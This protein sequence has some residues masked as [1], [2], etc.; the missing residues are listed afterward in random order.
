MQS[1]AENDDSAGCQPAHVLL[2]ALAEFAAGA[3]HEINNPLA[4]INGRAKILLEEIT[5][6]EH[7]K[8]L[9]V[10]IAQVKRAYEMIAD[11]R[12]FARPP[13]PEKTT[14]DVVAELELIAEEQRS[15]IQEDRVTVA[16]ET[17]VDSFFVSMDRTLF[18]T[19]VLFLCN[20]ARDSLHLTG[21]KIIIRLT[22]PDED[23]IEIAV[24]DSGKGV[25][26]D[27]AALMFN[28]YYSGRQAGRGLGFGLPKCWR[29]AQILGGTICYE[30]PARFVLTLPVR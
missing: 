19:A 26:D 3:G 16:V 5:D 27:V 13:E 8:Q 12:F 9:A 15:L 24:E 7:R 18:H 6:V 1:P 17:A 30:N 29:I 14:F 11:I 23:N 22:L 25:S 21:G 20:N 10:I 28:P 2:D 4:I